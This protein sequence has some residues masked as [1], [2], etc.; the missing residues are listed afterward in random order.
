MRGAQAILALRCIVKS[1][2]Y[3][4]AVRRRRASSRLSQCSGPLPDLSCAQQ[5]VF[6][7]STKQKNGSGMEL[8]VVFLPAFLNLEA[9]SDLPSLVRQTMKQLQ[10]VCFVPVSTTI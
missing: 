7:T 1:E 5:G 4:K 2:Q 8:N 3:D 10:P 6:T 9:A